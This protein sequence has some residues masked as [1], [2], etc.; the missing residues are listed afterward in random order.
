MNICFS[1]F[2]TRVWSMFGGLGSFFFVFSLARYYP[3]DFKLDF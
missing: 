1:V 3:V 2:N